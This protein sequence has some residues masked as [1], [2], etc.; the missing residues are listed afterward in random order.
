MPRTIRLTAPADGEVAAALAKLRD[1]LGVTPDF[2]AEALAEA[3]AATREPRLPDADEAAIPFVTID[4]PGSRD[5]DQ[6]LHLERHDVGFRVHYAIADVAAFVSPGGALDRE[7]HARGQTFYAPDRNATLYPPV[8]SEGAASLLPG[9]ERP[10][11]LWTLD[12][13]AAG[14]CTHVDVRR[15]RVR[16]REQLDYESVQRALDDGSAAEGLQLLREVGLLRQRREARLGGIDLPIPDQEVT[17]DDD[18]YG[19]AFRA[20]LPVEGWN[21]QISLLAGEAAAQL[22]L[23][24]GVGILRTLPRA[25]EGALARLRRTAAAL[26]VAWPE[27]VPYQ[28]FIRGLDPA[29]PPHAAVLAESTVLFRGS[30]YVAFDGAS[31]ADAKHAG[32]GAAYAHTTAPLRRLVDRYVSEVCVALAAGVDVPEWARAALPA[33]PETMHASNAR[34]GRYESGILSIVEAAVLGGSVGSVFDAV[35]VEK[36]ERGATIHL[37]EPAVTARSDGDLP[38]GERVRVRLAVA[39]VERREVRFAAA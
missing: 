1:D 19:L 8:L 21:A 5:L 38:L 23:D 33:L 18:G 14:A 26:A 31:P 7:A 34:A 17:R 25:D 12:V 4:P 36:D 29:N 2:P 28:D 22:M 10:A 32:V 24:G 39:D 37:V 20:Q 15:V 9:E 30:G 11:V 13:D 35:V 3:E 16:S 27:D 6:A